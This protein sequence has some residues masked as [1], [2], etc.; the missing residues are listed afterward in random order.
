MIITGSLVVL[1]YLFSRYVVGAFTS[2]ETVIDIAQTLLHIML[3]SSIVFGFS[4]VVSGVMRSSG[5]VLVPTAISVGCI[6]LIEVPSA[7]LLSRFFGLNGV[8]MAYPVTFVSML[9]FQSMYYRL[10]WR[11][12]E[13]VR[14]V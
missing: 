3:W 4:S 1:G 12:K 11:K 6:I 14:L 13:I 5:S 9:L 8:W 2:D 7:W 10:V